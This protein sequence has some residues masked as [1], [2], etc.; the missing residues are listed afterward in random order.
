[1]QYNKDAGGRFEKVLQLCLSLVDISGSLEIFDNISI[2]LCTK[3]MILIPRLV[4]HLVQALGTAKG[5]INLIT[6]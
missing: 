3:N 5:L 1:M 6:K 4:F 2:I